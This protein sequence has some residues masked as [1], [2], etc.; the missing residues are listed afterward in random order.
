M[1]LSD[2]YKVSMA[3][4]KHGLIEVSVIYAM[5]QT[6]TEVTLKVPVGTTAREAIARSG[7]AA[8]HSGVDWDAVAVGIFGKR[9]PISTELRDHDRVE[10]YRP[11]IADPK[12]AR[13]KRA[14]LRVANRT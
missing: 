2:V 9:A 14:R 8:K 4:A 10:I 6:Q 11:L 13:R 3:D 5:P 7:I 12:Q 1:P